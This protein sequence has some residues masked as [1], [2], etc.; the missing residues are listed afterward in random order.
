[1]IKKYVIAGLL[2]TFCLTLAFAQ[3]KKLPLD[4]SVRMGTLPNGFSYFIKTN[5]QPE[6]RATLYLAN[7]VGSIL[8][9]E[10]ERGLAHFLEH[11][12]SMEPS[13]ILKMN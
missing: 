9:E 7:K 3:D 1:M 8:E 5:K 12:T 6:K 2:S 11:M 4:S 10:N 13:I